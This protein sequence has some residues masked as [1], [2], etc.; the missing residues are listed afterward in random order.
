MV[1]E[2]INDPRM[3]PDI[4][5]KTICNAFLLMLV[6]RWRSLLNSDRQFKSEGNISKI[7]GAEKETVASD[8][9]LSRALEWIDPEELK[10]LWGSILKTLRKKKVHKEGTVGNL[11]AAALDMT[12]VGNSKKISCGLCHG[13]G[14][15]THKVVFGY[16]IG[17][18]P[19]V[20]LGLE[21]MRPGEGE[22]EAAGRL[23][24]WIHE[25]TGNW[26]DVFALDGL[27]KLPFIRKLRELGYHTVIRTEEVRLNIIR[28]AIRTYN[29]Q[30]PVIVEQSDDLSYELNVWDGFEI[31]VPEL[32]VPLRVLEVAKNYVLEGVSEVYWIITTLPSQ[33]A[34]AA[35][36]KEIA[37]CRWHIENNAYHNL[38]TYWYFKHTFCHKED[39]SLTTLW[40]RIIAF[41]FF[42]LFIYR[43]L[44]QLAQLLRERKI[45]MVHLVPMLERS[46]CIPA[47]T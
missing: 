3:G 47:P 18:Q 35:L 45:M 32:D 26:I 38:K 27:Y 17:R 30:L 24:E 8:S 11:R 37:H 31:Q 42:M 36:V 44:F 46:L 34:N 16:V 10:K 2:Q 22:V 43:H 7:I 40:F 6:L 21:A 13:S 19:H 23:A 4:S 12:G 25:T 41:S 5:R 20:F 28:Q 15:K 39:A 9:T 33:R 29:D 1:N 14:K